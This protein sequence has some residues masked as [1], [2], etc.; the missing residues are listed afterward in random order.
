MPSKAPAAKF[1]TVVDADGHVRETTKGAV[2]WQDL[3]PERYRSQLPQWMPFDTGGGRF[4]L[5]GHLWPPPYGNHSMKGKDIDSV[6]ASHP[7]MWDPKLR[8]PDM[9]AEGIDIAVLFGGGIA[10]GAST[11]ADTGLGS[12]MAHAFNTWL[13]GYCKASPERLKGVAALNL[14]DV[15]GAIGELERCVKE[16]G[17]VA[18]GMPPNLRGKNIGDEGFNPI[19]AAAE[20]LDVPVCSHMVGPIPGIAGHYLF[21]DGRAR[22]KFEDHCIT[23]PFEEMIAIMSVVSG[24]ALDRFPKL[25]VAFLEGNAGWLPWWMDRLDGHYA[26]I[27]HQVACKAKPSEYMTGGQCYFSCE[28]EESTLPFV[29]E[30]VGE[31][32]MLYASDYWHFDTEYWGMVKKLKTYPGLTDSARRKILGENALRLYNLSS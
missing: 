2:P 8:L 16:L 5:D 4:Y 18:V 28:A 22:T 14:A 17:F 26:S 10:L 9:D 32:R 13:A 31:D 29:V 30:R 11:I 7:G 19:F 6:H 15:E 24:G 27:G 23:Q 12:A 20:R 21:F 1:W 25:R 3:V